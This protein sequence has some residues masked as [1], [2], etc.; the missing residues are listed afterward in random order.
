MNEVPLGWENGNGS[1]D[2]EMPEAPGEYPM[3]ENATILAGG[4]LFGSTGELV[5]CWTLW[6]MKWH[7][8]FSQEQKRKKLMLLEKLLGGSWLRFPNNLPP[9]PEDEDEWDEDEFYYD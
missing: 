5:P 2:T 8:H 1:S 3:K 9:G 7:T 6:R 4:S